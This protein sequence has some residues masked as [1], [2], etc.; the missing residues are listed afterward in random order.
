MKHSRFRVAFIMI[1]AN[2]ELF[3]RTLVFVAYCEAPSCSIVSCREMSL[4]GIC[5]A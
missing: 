3:S 1:R 5:G 2:G 4:H